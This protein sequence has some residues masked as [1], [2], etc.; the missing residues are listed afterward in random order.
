MNNSSCLANTSNTF[1]KQ[2]VLI[3]NAVVGLY[4]YAYFDSCC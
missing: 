4:L 2:F 3:L 1:S